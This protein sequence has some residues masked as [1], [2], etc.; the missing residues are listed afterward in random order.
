[1]SGGGFSAGYYGEAG[2]DR[3]AE[4]FAP[5]RG[6]RLF[7]SSSFAVPGRASAV[8]ARR[9]GVNA[10]FLSRGGHFPLL[11]RDER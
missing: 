10:K 8:P 2:G 5:S 11:G 7:S 9:D 1:V 3:V 4:P 6:S